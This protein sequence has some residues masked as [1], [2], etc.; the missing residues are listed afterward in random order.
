MKLSILI[1][2][3]N[4]SKYLLKNLELLNQYIQKGNYLQKIEI[5]VSNNNSP[6]NTHDLVVSFQKENPNLLLRYFRQA[7]NI[8]LEKNALFV[9]KISIADYIMFLGDDDYIDYRYLTKVEELLRY[10]TDIFCIIPSNIPINQ[11]GELLGG[12]RD[13]NL[14]TKEYQAGFSN[15]LKNSWRGHQLSGLVLKRDGLYSEYKNRRVSNI[16]LFIHLV[17][18]SCLNGKTF[19]MT[20]F[21][22]KVTAAPQ[23]NKDW[24]YGEDG[25]FNEIFDNYKRLPLNFIQITYL[26]LY[27]LLKQPSRLWNYRRI[28]NKNFLYAFYKIWL[29]KNSTLGFKLIFPIVVFIQFIF[30]VLKKLIS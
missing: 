21:P 27:H 12:G 1:P 23:E 7:E 18:I 2:T 26:Q 3:Y 10:G 29:S 13:L 28:S 6:D 25:L 24:N 16:Y 30:K 9:L 22:V 11:K 19:H 14:P 4:R 15:C 5:I 17:G 8:G 20:D